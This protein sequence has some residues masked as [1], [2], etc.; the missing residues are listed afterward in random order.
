MDVSP[1]DSVQLP[2]GQTVGDVSCVCFHPV[3]PSVYVGLKGSIVEYDILSGCQIG[4][5][6][7][8]MPAQYLMFLQPK[9]AVVVCSVDG[10]IAVVD[11]TEGNILAEHQPS[12]HTDDR[13]FLCAALHCPPFVGANPVLVFARGGYRAVTGVNLFAQNKKPL[14]FAGHKTAVTCVTTHPTLNV[15]AVA[16]CDGT[17]RVFDMST[18]G[19]YNLIEGERDKDGIRHHAVLQFQNGGRRVALPKA[20][21][22]SKKSG[23]KNIASIYDD[24]R[25]LVVAERGAVAYYDVSISG[26][27]SKLADYYVP[28]S[29]FRDAYFH[30]QWKD[31]AFCLD[32]KGVLR[33]LYANKDS[34]AAVESSVAAFLK[35]NQ[36]L[37]KSGKQF[38]P[39]AC[40]FSL[41]DEFEN[42]GP[43]RVSVG[44]SRSAH[45]GPPAGSPYTA[46]PGGGG[47]GGGGTTS[48]GEKSLFPAPAAGPGGGGADDPLAAER[49][50]RC[51]MHPAAAYFVFCGPDLAEKKSKSLP[52][53][54][55]TSP[56]NGR[57]SA[58]PLHT[59]LTP[60][61]GYWLNPSAASTCP[62]EGTVFSASLSGKNEILLRCA[63]LGVPGSIAFLSITPKL[64]TG[65]VM[66]HCMPISLV[67]T[68]GALCLT[69][70]H[71]GRVGKGARYW[72]QLPVAS[73][74]D[75]C[76]AEKAQQPA[77]QALGFSAGT[78]SH[79]SLPDQADGVPSVVVIE[80]EGR[81]LSL[82]PPSSTAP[83][84]SAAFEGMLVAALF[85]VGGLLVAQ[86]SQAN[87]KAYARVLPALW[88][89]VAAMAPVGHHGGEVGGG[90]C[91]ELDAEEKLVEAVHTEAHNLIGLCTSRRAMLVDGATLR[92]LATVHAK[93]TSVFPRMHSLHWIG[94]CLCVASEGA[95]L[96]LAVDGGVQKTSSLPARCTVAGVLHDRMVLCTAEG[97]DTV[98]VWVKHMNPFATVC[99]GVLAEQSGSGARAILLKIAPFYD[100]RRMP[101]YLLQQL[102]RCGL[103]DLA[104]KLSELNTGKSESNPFTESR[105]GDGTHLVA[106]S[107]QTSCKLHIISKD[108]A[109]AYSVLQK[110]IQQVHCRPA[111]SAKSPRVNEDSSFFQTA[112]VLLQHAVL[113]SDQSLAHT[114]ARLMQPLP[115]IKALRKCND[116][117]SLSA[118]ASCLASTD[119]PASRLAQALSQQIRQ[120]GLGRN[121]PAA[122]PLHSAPMCPAGGPSW[123]LGREAAVRT[124]VYSA[125]G[126]E[127]REQR[128]LEALSRSDLGSYFHSAT[129]AAAA[130]LSGGAGGE[131]QGGM[132]SDDDG[133][134]GF[135]D[136]GS[137]KVVSP[138]GFED[139]D[140][141]SNPGDD[142]EVARQQEELRRQY[143]C[144]FAGTDADDAGGGGDDDDDG[145]GANRK[146]KKFTINKDAV[147]EQPVL[148]NI[149]LDFAPAPGAAVNRRRQG[150]DVDGD[151]LAVPSSNSPNLEDGDGPSLP[152]SYLG[153]SAPECLRNG[154]QKLERNKYDD[155]LRRM[156]ASLVYLKN[157]STQ[158][159][160][161][162]PLEQVAYYLV[163]IKMLKEVK[164]L[165]KDQLDE[166]TARLGLLTYLVTKLPLQK[167]HIS[168]FVKKGVRWNM[169]AEDYGLAVQC[170]EAAEE[171]EKFDDDKEV[172]KDNDLANASPHAAQLVDPVSFCW[173][174]FNPLANDAAAA[175]CSYCPAIYST[176]NDKGS[177][178]GYCTYGTIE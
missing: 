113:H 94:S 68:A 72:L 88:A 91:F 47:A 175:R 116:A 161:K 51:C 48:P 30:T 151:R 3:L 138:D 77:K 20:K 100:T 107:W 65:A 156:N 8:R 127:D 34:V 173:A 117:A 129:A 67:K 155:A 85:R 80:S 82:Y 133:D 29:F 25:L 121:E 162:T 7:L 10:R 152:P 2:P 101:Q 43:C 64:P 40:A 92:L 135:D 160:K 81:A 118:A 132:D 106:T 169:N 6:P 111:D 55:L 123:D 57:A 126:G 78:A 35:R 137:F 158:V 120:L 14:V 178:C 119:P 66:E 21:K 147:F 109:S 177:T 13:P 73:V 69:V 114:V 104:S 58:I 41:L 97:E 62:M 125:V 42:I 9:N 90:G 32:H 87:G 28:G 24:M 167:K 54:H 59:T 148:S 154:F 84:A 1:L 38:R 36:E 63:E 141:R 157:D 136:D 95:V 110:A 89:D 98:D 16:A 124:S 56:N 130:K 165:E 168:S 153:T 86:V 46:G 108:L 128:V 49:G 83:Q 163:C 19:L 17:V 75:H 134:D 115:L 50:L 79:A 61:D 18:T 102:S 27:P 71:N 146:F 44:E 70:Q 93:R 45:A 145:F 22:A 174:T 143:L 139:T 99:R 164:E 170:I 176:A 103:P 60:P 172:C 53:Y 52:I 140:T 5:F 166:D 4:E 31:V 15:L 142:D 149:T 122:P 105:L 171:P 12:K 112:V 96:A 74:R 11:V 144:T 23:R 39:N 131:Q 26:A 37:K 33:A 150:G 76:R 159:A